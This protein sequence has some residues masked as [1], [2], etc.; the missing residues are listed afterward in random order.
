MLERATGCLENAGRRVLQDANGVIRNK[1]SLPSHFWHHS[2]HGKHAPNWFSA[3]LLASGQR[4]FSVPSKQHEPRGFKDETRPPLDFLYPHQARVLVSSPLIRTQRRTRSR[5]RGIGLGFSR[6]YGAIPA[7]SGATTEVLPGHE[8]GGQQI[9]E[10]DYS[11]PVQE[12]RQAS[13]DLH[14]FLRKDGTEYDK[15][16]VLYV[17]AGH[18]PN[19]RSALCSYMSKSRRPKERARA[20]RLFNLIPRK[21]RTES[22]F[23]NILRSLTDLPSFEKPSHLE[24]LCKEALSTPT[25]L[26]EIVKPCLFHMLKNSQWNKIAYVWKLVTQKKANSG[27]ELE[28]LLDRFSHY[29]FPEYSLARHL[30]RL[31]YRLKQDK[32]GPLHDFARLLIHRFIDS[33]ALL[34][35]T[36]I[37]TFLPLL[38]Q[39]DSLGLVD[40]RDYVKMIEHFVEKSGEERAQFVKCVLLYH[41]CRVAF[42]HQEMMDEELLNKIIRGVAEFGMV[43][44]YPYFLNEFARL[45]GKPSRFIYKLIMHGFADTGNVAAVYD[46]FERAVADYGKPRD[47][48]MLSPLLLVHA[49]LA[50]VQETRRQ[51]DRTSEEFHIKPNVVFWNILVLAHCKARD[52]TGAI[53]VLTE[54]RQKGVKATP[55]S[56]GPLMALFA[57][58]GDIDSVRALYNYAQKNKVEITRPMLDTAV[59]AY[60]KN[61]RMSEAEELV[62]KGWHVAEGGSPVTMWNNILVEYAVRVSKNSFRRILDRMEKLGLVPNAMTYAAIM[63]AYVHTGTP[64]RARDTLRRMYNLGIQPTEQ[65]FSI[66]MT[67][68]A[69]QR[70]RD[71]VRAIYQEIETRFGK[72]GI[73]SSLAQLR[74]QITRDLENASDSDMEPENVILK[75]A[76]KTII[77]SIARFNSDTSAV[78]CRQP[79]TGLQIGIPDKKAFTALHFQQLI[80]AYGANAAPERA[81]DLLRYYMKHSGDDLDSIPMG[82]VVPVMLAC[83][84]SQR[85][86]QVQECW[87]IMLPNVYKVGGAFDIDEHL[88]AAL[89]EPAEASRTSTSSTP[90]TPAKAP[91]ILHGNRFILGSALSIYLRSLAGLGEF[92]KTHQVVKE[93]QEAGFELTGLNWSAF[94]EVL[95]RS[96]DYS[97]N[98]EAFRLFEEKFVPWFPGWSWF[99]IGYGIR[100]IDTPVTILHLE[101]KL[102]VTKP[103]RMM[104]KKARRQWRIIRPDYM[105]PHYPTMVYL[106]ST[107]KRFR[108]ESIEDGTERLGI[109]YKVAPKTVA[110]LASMPYIHDPYQAEILRGHKPTKRP[111]PAPIKLS[112]SPF[113]VLGGPDSRLKRRS[114]RGATIEPFEFDG[115]EVGDPKTTK[116]TKE[117]FGVEEPTAPRVPE[118]IFEFDFS[119]TSQPSPTSA[120][121]QPSKSDPPAVDKSS[122]AS[123]TRKPFKLGRPA[124]DQ[125]SLTGL[126]TPSEQKALLGSTWDFLPPEDRITLEKELHE[127]IE[128]SSKWARQR[129]RYKKRIT[130]AFK[131]R[132]YDLANNIRARWIK[133]K[134]MRAEGRGPEGRLFDRLNRRWKFRTHNW[135]LLKVDTGLPMKPGRRKKRPKHK[136]AWTFK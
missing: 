67:G 70:N 121:Q 110:I 122:T 116:A 91:K 133:I 117:S 62:E 114:F 48:W 115:Y 120:T 136:R 69:K 127:Q 46:I 65:H 131:K 60:V 1:S 13:A 78:K 16:W 100:P 134:E 90:T 44:S 21:D 128:M 113:G 89:S 20:W 93:V 71:M 42:P 24:L 6:S 103:R 125:P 15:A 53:K 126:V 4:S 32:S 63:L 55:Y 80:H 41:Q 85:F 123:A 30:I 130:S 40:H 51:F 2:D 112:S 129:E 73:D 96:G 109:L 135:R 37:T 36:P 74:T 84:R 104:G 18:P 17:A 86:E 132:N 52:V 45:F 105:H 124:V 8:D 97:D 66:L 99:K 77:Q 19:F 107:L 9:E 23:E 83:L 34:R 50:D 35:I 28:P 64:D 39:Y 119:A 81:L 101:G 3:L 111:L 14:A 12:N 10:P 5:R 82:F 108:H 26:L 87:D 106:A 47:P 79:I 57:K 43:Q 27:L 22:D 11:Q 102:G 7:L 33:S 56:L 98:L 76:E 92:E 88:G 59:Q 25:P 54:M 31:G 94:I 72:V 75:N 95:A 61:G 58:R 118:N 29:E 49:R 38:R 68:Y